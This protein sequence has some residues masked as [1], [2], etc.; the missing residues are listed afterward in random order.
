MPQPT[1]ILE[2]KLPHQKPRVFRFTEAEIVLGYSSRAHLALGPENQNATELTIQVDLVHG[3]RVAG[4]SGSQVIRLNGGECQLRSKLKA[5]DVLA[6]DAWEVAILAAFVPSSQTPSSEETRPLNLRPL[7]PNAGTGEKE[8][9]AGTVPLKASPAASIGSNKKSELDYLFLFFAPVSEFL[10]DDD[11]AEIMINGPRQIYVEKRGKLQAVEARFP[12]EQALQAAVMNVAR[13]MGRL[14]DKDN[15]R[16]DA[17]L[18][19][20]SRV[21]AVMPILSRAGTTVA[22]RKFKREK[23]TLDQ[24]VR[25]GSLTAEG[26][27]L[28]DVIVKLGKNLIVSGATSSGKTSVLNVLSALIP[29]HERILVL[30]DA[31]ELQLQQI[32]KVCFE[33]RKADEH[34]KGEVTIRDLL[35]SALRLRPDR[36]VVGEIRGGEA[37]DLLQ[38]MNTGHEGSMS[39]IHANTA[40]DSLFR[41]ETCAMMSGIELPLSALRQQIVSGIQ[42]VIQTAR[43]FDGSRKIVGITE[44]L[45]L[46]DG[47]YVCEDIYKFVSSGISSEGR[48]IGRHAF[49]GYVPS[50]A[51]LAKERGLAVEFLP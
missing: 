28:L 16:L 38:A 31:S 23:L 43:L 45:G 14:F 37:L 46:K 17:R 30:E 29:E 39:T 20:G 12:S 10:A 33:T 32:H 51:A 3:T 48:I 9:E 2:L 5:G 15:P 47:H 1:T 19:D 41:M 34:G 40:R 21:H 50:F 26:A 36:L 27:Q 13:S 11:V 35:H 42:V 7:P 8:D 22:I 24:L 6:T 49:T 44:V 18:P 4:L 25:F